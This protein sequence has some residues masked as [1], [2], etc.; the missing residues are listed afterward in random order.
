MEQDSRVRADAAAFPYKY[1][2]GS[3]SE[4]NNRIIFGGARVSA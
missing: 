4:R 2:N 1:G 3:K